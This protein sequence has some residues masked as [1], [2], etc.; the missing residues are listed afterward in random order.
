MLSIPLVRQGIESTSRDTHTLR[1][2][3]GEALAT[4]HEAP[5][6]LT[7]LTAK[8]M[9]AVPEPRPDELATVMAEAGRIFAT[10]TIEGQTPDG[11]CHQQALA[12]GVP[13][14]VPRR[15]LD[16]LEHE[17]GL[18]PE[19]VGVQRPVGAVPGHPARWARRGSVLGVVAPSN[20]PA[21]HLG[22]L[23]AVALGYGVAVRPGA[24]DPIT[25]LRLVRALLQAGLP[26]G[27]L[28]LLPGPHA[29]ADTLVAAADL[30]LVY[31]GESTV[32]RL[33]GDS[34]VLVHGPGRSKILVDAPVDDGLLDHL[35]AEIAEDGG[36]RCTNT[37]VVLTSGDHHALAA[38]LAERLAA[39]P[40]RPVTD[41]DAALPARPVKEALALRQ[42]LA[43]AAEGAPDL[44]EP[45]YNGEL[46]P[47]VDGDAAVLRPA[48]VCVDRSDHPGLRT[49]L[50]F[51]CVWVAP[52]RPAEGIAP[53]RDSL[54]VTLIGTDPA[55]AHEALRTSSIRTVVHGRVPGWWRDP[56]LPHEGYAGQFLRDVRGYV[57]PSGENS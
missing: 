1:S 28:S 45:Y 48:V 43:E 15:T 21:T 40:V 57:V 29:A 5:P 23:K 16:R 34:R 13:V 52:W 49:E 26:A 8:A 9:R 11:Y 50:P 4:V 44:T 30:A 56:Y 19:V 25:P 47:L 3:T 20:H 32:A 14:G 53:L 39:L 27:L 42:A 18:L 54:V 31:G 12:A 10:E 17:V 41:P 2:V 35:V 55:L 46:A 7:R 36:V 24:R 33:R 38:A 22:W 37:S 6:L 51:P